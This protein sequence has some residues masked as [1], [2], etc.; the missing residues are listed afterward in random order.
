MH[1]KKVDFLVAIFFAAEHIFNQPLS[2]L[3]SS[4]FRSLTL[5][6][7]FCIASRSFGLVLMLVISKT[8]LLSYSVLVA[9]K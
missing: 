5:A 4:H 2:P 8:D 1:K 6:A 7:W 9:V 3:L